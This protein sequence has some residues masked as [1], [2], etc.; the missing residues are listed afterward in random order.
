MK[1][2]IDFDD[3]I[4]NTKQF[5][6]YLGKFYAEN[7]VSHELVQKYY[8]D[9]GD[10]NPIKVFNPWGLFARLEKY[11]GMD[12]SKLRENFENQLKELDRFVF[13]DAKPFLIKIGKENVHLVSFGLPNFQEN[14]IVGSGINELVSSFSITENLKA[15]MISEILEKEKI[16]PGKKI[17]FIDDRVE[18]IEDVKKTLPDAVTIFLHR[19]EGRYHDQ[20][21]DYCDYEVHSLQ[22]AEEII[23]KL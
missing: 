17:V 14:K 23:S 15:R 4:F 18:Q 9:S 8:Y 10:A 13:A 6:D 16:K 5:R 22:E 2:F 21:T 19:Q 3:V 12:I 1:I 20:K 11:E 7:G